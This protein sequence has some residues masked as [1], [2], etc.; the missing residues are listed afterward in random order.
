LKY[1]REPLT[2]DDVR[3]LESEVRGTRDKLILW[4]LLDTGLRVSELCALR[5]ANMDSSRL[6]LRVVGKGSK[7]RIVPLTARARDVLVQWW[8]RS[9]RYRKLSPRTV[10]RCVAS[11]AQ[12][13]E[14]RRT[15]TPHVLRHTFACR[16]I[17]RGVGLPFLSK[18]LGH[19]FVTT[20]Q[21]YLN[22]SGDDV[23]EAFRAAYRVDGS[24]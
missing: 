11:L 7:R 20:T 9:L 2:D 1:L 10:Q 6:A 19:S 22:L 16:A 24:S 4:V 15:V 14:L 5:E 18:A 17:R 12:R 21:G 13:A 8:L 3:A 23:L